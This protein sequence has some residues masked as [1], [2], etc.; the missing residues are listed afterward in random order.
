MFLWQ[1]VPKFLI[2]YK[3][4]K[5]VP[6][7]S[8]NKFATCCGISKLEAVCK[9]IAIT[10]KHLEELRDYQAKLLASIKTHKN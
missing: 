3:R 8:V 6:M 1:I 10:E 5:L 2:D 7:N 9:M 4:V